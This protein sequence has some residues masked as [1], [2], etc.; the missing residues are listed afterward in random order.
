MD[1]QDSLEPTFKLGSKGSKKKKKAKY[2]HTDAVLDLSWNSNLPH[3]LASGSVDESVIL[4]DL[5]EGNPHTTIRDFNEKVQTLKFHHAEAESLLVGSCDGTVKVFDCRATDNTQSEF[6]SWDVKAEVERVSWNRHN[7]NCFIASTNDGKVHYFDRRTPTSA[8]WSIDA[9][10]KE[11]TGLVLSGNVDGMLATASADGYLKVW[12]YD[13]N[14]A[15]QV[16]VKHLKMGV[17]QALA[18]CPENSF[19]LSVGGDVRKKNLQRINLID[20]EAIENRFKNRAA[21]PPTTAMEEM[22]VN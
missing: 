22:S 7:S 8:L 13:Q 19:V 6:Q 20:I 12:D 14:G 4:W 10:E 18:E 5:D 2:G 3:I 17:I 11:V 1:I 9:H 21:V 16:W 15:T